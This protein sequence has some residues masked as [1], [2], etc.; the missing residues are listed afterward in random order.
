MAD[1]RTVE[2]TVEYFEL[3]ASKYDKLAARM[4][5]EMAKAQCIAKAEAYELAAFELKRNMHQDDSINWAVEYRS[6]ESQ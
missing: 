5:G 4:Q 1:K 3:L 6:S 2:E